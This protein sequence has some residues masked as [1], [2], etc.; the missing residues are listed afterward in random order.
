MEPNVHGPQP[1]DRVQVETCGRVAAVES[2]D[3]VPGVIVE[4]DS[5]GRLWVRVD[6]VLL[7]RS[8]AP[9]RSIT[10][11]SRLR[12]CSRSSVARRARRRVP[13]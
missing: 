2:R 7:L 13:V 6:D 5:A 4:L 10:G 11:P 12:S 9:N 3:G 1:S 8:P